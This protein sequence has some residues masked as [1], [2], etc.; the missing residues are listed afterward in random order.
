MISPV[1]MGELL[2]VRVS[3]HNVITGLEVEVTMNR[4]VTLPDP[5]CF[6]NEAWQMHGMSASITYFSAP[7]RRY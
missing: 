6:F 4:A 1:K 7:G 5:C 2:P 3:R